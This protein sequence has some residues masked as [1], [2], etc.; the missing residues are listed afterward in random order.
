MDWQN[1]ILKNGNSPKNG[2]SIT[3]FHALVIKSFWLLWSQLMS[4]TG[5]QSTIW[6]TK[7]EILYSRLISRVSTYFCELKFRDS[8]RYHQLATN[9]KNFAGENFCKSV[10]TCEKCKNLHPAK[11]NSYIV[12]LL[13]KCNQASKNTVESP[14]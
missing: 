12:W 2:G 13:H 11:L 7:C 1:C 9:T 4:V 3:T 10:P 8:I 6:R 5:F 14:Y